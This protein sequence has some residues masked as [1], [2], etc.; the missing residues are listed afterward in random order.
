MSEKPSVARFVPWDTIRSNRRLRVILS[1]YIAAWKMSRFPRKPL[2]TSELVGACHALISTLLH[3]FQTESL[4]FVINL[5]FLSLPPAS[6]TPADVVSSC[7]PVK[8]FGPEKLSWHF[9]GSETARHLRKSICHPL[10]NQAGTTSGGQP[11]G[12]MPLSL[13]YY[14]YFSISTTSKSYS[15]TKTP[16]ELYVSQVLSLAGYWSLFSFLYSKRGQQG[17]PHGKHC[18]PT[19][20]LLLVDAAEN[21]QF[22]LRL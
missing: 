22:P 19:H 4:H 6:G 1:V 11:T 8:S 10:A 20:F 9:P 17:F 15:R 2:K 12:H 3:L 7:C 16:A 14:Y 5:S 21:R 18:R 13:Y